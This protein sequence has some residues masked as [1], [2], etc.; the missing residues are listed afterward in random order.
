MGLL[1]IL[2]AVVQERLHLSYPPG[3]LAKSGHSF[4]S[5]LATIAYACVFGL[6]MSFTTKLVKSFVAR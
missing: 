6:C 3:V 2:A 5:F 4:L 1:V